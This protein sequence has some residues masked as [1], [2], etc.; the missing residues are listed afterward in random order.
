MGV[1]TDHRRRL[2]TGLGRLLELSPLPR[3]LEPDDARGDGEHEP[4]P[5]VR[6]TTAVGSRSRAAVVVIGR[7]CFARLVC[8]AASARARGLG[9]QYLR[10]WLAGE[11]GASLR[12]CPTATRHRPARVGPAVRLSVRAA[13]IL[14]L[15]D[16]PQ[17]WRWAILAGQRRQ[18][19]P[20]RA[21]RSPARGS[22]RQSQPAGDVMRTL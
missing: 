12:T 13:M 22:A 11:H 14:T 17:T 20:T 8:R 16:A 2:R 21:H 1:P 10:P 6:D 18:R 15:A 9:H 4:S 3:R 5:P 19:C 7:R